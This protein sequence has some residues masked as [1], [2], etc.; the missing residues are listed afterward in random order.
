DL[1]RRS[2]GGHIQVAVDV[3]DRPIVEGDRGQL[4]QVI[5]NLCLNGRDAMPNGGAITITVG[6]SVFNTDAVREIPGAREGRCAYVSVRDDVRPRI[7]EPFFTTKPA[8]RGAGLGLSTVYAIAERHGGFVAVETAMNVGTTLTVYFPDAGT[9]EP[10]RH[11]E[12][13][14][15]VAA[16]AGARGATILLAEDEPFVRDLAVEMLEH[17]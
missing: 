8:G 13:R 11:P 6:R 17:A 4:E 5:I 15:S 14:A 2:L 9:A 16:I 1:L 3:R 12:P 10:T 7:F